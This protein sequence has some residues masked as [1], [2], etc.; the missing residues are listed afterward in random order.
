MNMPH[1]LRDLVAVVGMR[2]TSVGRNTEEIWWTDGGVTARV[3]PT[4]RGWSWNTRDEDDVI[5]EQSRSV[6][7]SGAMWAAQRSL[8][9]HLEG[10]DR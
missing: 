9:R 2:L 8:R 7:C 4:Y 6:S 10:V 5:L 1:K 3:Y